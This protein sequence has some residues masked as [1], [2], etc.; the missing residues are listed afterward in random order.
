MKQMF[1]L[2]MMSTL[3]RKSRWLI[4]IFNQ[5]LIGNFIGIFFKDTVFYDSDSATF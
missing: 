3:S 1:D 2:A 4:G 5:V